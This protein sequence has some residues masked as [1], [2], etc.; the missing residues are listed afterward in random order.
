MKRLGK[1]IGYGMISKLPAARSCL[2]LSCRGPLSYRNQSFDLQSKSKD[3]FLYDNGLRHE[4]VNLVITSIM[5]N[6]MIC[7]KLSQKSPSDRA[8]F[9]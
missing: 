9:K 5:M 3:W 2:T 6:V 7:T 1:M 4:R 8:P